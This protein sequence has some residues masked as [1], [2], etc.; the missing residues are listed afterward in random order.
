[1]TT[2]FRAR[3]TV[4]A[5]LALVILPACGGGGGNG[6]TTPPVTQ[7]PSPVRT[8][9]VQ[10][11]FSLVGIAEAQRQGAPADYVRHEFTTA[12]T[13]TLEVNAD[14]TF[15]SSQMLVGVVRGFCS[16]DQID[17]ALNGGAVACPEVDGDFPSP[18]PARLT[19]T[20]LAAGNYTLI[21]ANITNNNE[22]GNYQVF[23]TR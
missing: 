17:A 8:L 21:I 15:S 10:G 14:W 2:R 4:A 18:K 9:I 11:G 23:L 22:S 16:F 20:N 19:I 6:P 13:G 5:A 1:M 7:A 3:G 12:G